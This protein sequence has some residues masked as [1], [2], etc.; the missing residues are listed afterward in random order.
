M[1]DIQH[2]FICRP[3]DFTVS[4][5]AGIEPRTVATIRHWLSDALTTR[6]DLTFSP[7]KC[8][9]IFYKV[10]MLL[11][12][13]FCF[14][15]S[16]FCL[17]PNVKNR[18]MKQTERKFIQER[19]SLY[20]PF[21]GVANFFVGMFWKPRKLA[22]LSHTHTITIPPK[23]PSVRRLT[24]TTPYN[25]KVLFQVNALWEWFL[26]RVYNNMY[27]TVRSIVV[28]QYSALI[29]N[30]TRTYRLLFKTAPK[31]AKISLKAC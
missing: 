15:F 16:C 30:I 10:V 9:L 28:F 29:K 18:G 23:K 26:C 31:T 5:N 25:D 22:L 4:E 13:L 6:L 21:Q 7:L 27:Y 1:Y 19:S 17:L 11:Q 3:S 14:Q 12:W 2:C 8:S 24:H 20:F